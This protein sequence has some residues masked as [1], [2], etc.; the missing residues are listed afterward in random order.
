MATAAVA[1]MTI[2]GF[3]ISLMYDNT[4]YRLE[5]GEAIPVFTVDF[6]KYGMSNSVGLQSAEKQMKHIRE[7]SNLA[8]FPILNIINADMMSFSYFFKQKKDRMY[9]KEDIYQ[10][11]K[12]G[13]DNKV[14]HVKKIRN[15]I[16]GFPSHIYL[17]SY[18]CAHEVWHEDYLVDI[19]VPEYYFSNEETE[20]IFVDGIGEITSE[21][22]P[23]IVM[24]KLK[25]KQ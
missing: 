25:K 8:S 9:K 5:A 11:I 21:D 12:F 19:V 20:K 15:D 18:Y 22:D 7:M 24:M 23:V 17:S 10:Y 13:K 6:G 1:I 14:H 16:T 2:S 3:N 4:F